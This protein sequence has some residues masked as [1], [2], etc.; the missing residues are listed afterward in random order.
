MAV[1]SFVGNNKIKKVIF[2]MFLPIHK[3]L[4]KKWKP[5]SPSNGKKKKKNQGL[6]TL[7]I[8]G[9]FCRIYNISPVCIW[10]KLY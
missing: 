9:D 4:I 1:F 5:V 10:V 3:N 6:V 8:Q 7:V 2:K